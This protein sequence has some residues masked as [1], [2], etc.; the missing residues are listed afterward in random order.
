MSSGAGRRAPEIG[1]DDP[2]QGWTRRG[3]TWFR[4][5]VE[6]AR[7]GGGGHPLIAASRVAGAAVY[8]RHGRRAGRIVDLA[9]DASSGAIVSARIVTGGLLGIGRRTYQA[10]WADLAYD[11]GRNRY[12]LPLDSAEIDRA[13]RLEP[14][15]AAWGPAADQG[16]WG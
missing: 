12:L 2:F 13:S 15:R 6:S 7:P 14:M 16:G 1:V 3:G 9:F 5:P 10:A 8:D 4:P 11:P